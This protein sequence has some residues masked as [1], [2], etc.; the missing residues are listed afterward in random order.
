M[1]ISVRNFLGFLA[2]A[3]FLA[4]S[5]AVASEDPPEVTEEGLHRVHDS[6][7]G[8]VYTLPDV[9]WTP[10]E[11]FQ[12]LEPYVAFKKDWQRNYNRSRSS[13]R[14]NQDEM[15]EIKQRLAKEFDKVFR[16]V[17]DEKGGYPVVDAAGEDTLILRPAIINLDVQAPDRMT[18]GMSRTYAE[19]AGAMT[20][21]LE[22]YD[23]VSGAL[24]AKGLDAQA[25]RQTGFMT[26]QTGA[27]NAQAARRIL[28]GWAQTLVDALDEIHG[29]ND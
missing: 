17:L 14:I 11:K 2:A 4:A 23:S 27:S 13:Y 24:L 1:T 20:L 12:L 22:I 3:T 7:W 5:T 25:D 29:K 6:K 16:E 18:P 28:K 21:Y 26:W 15:D 9:D 8:L 10:Y 19:S